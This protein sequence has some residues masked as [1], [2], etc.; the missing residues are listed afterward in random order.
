[1]AAAVVLFRVE[2]FEVTLL[3]ARNRKQSRSGSCRVGRMLVD[4]GQDALVSFYA[5]PQDKQ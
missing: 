5:S 2:R 3:H 1:M 4:G